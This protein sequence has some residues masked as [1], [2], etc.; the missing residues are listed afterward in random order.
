MTRHTLIRQT[1]RAWWFTPDGTTDRPVLGALVGE[2]GALIVDAGASP[3]HAAEFQAALAAAGLPEP[4]WVALSHWHWDHVFGAA[5]FRA[6]LIAQAG[7]ARMLETMRGWSWD[8]AALDERVA[9]GVEIS[10]CRDMIKAELP[11][12]RDLRLRTADLSF[13]DE[14]TIDL[15]GVSCQL[16]HVGGDHAEDSTIIH[17]PG[18]GVA[19]LSDALYQCIYSEP[20]H[21]TLERLRPA[22]RRALDLGAE[23]YLWGHNPEPMGRAELI[24]LADELIEA[25]EIAAEQGGNL[26]ASAAEMERRRGR[27]LNEDEQE[28][29]AAF[30]NGFGLAGGEAG[31]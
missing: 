28:D 18:E 21:Y 27:P 9:A 24:R 8:D 5:A 25:G 10:F 19:F 4:A 12:R 16:I 11:D 7:T 26:A 13:G 15:G 1:E 17:L 30:C 31:R 23:C 29:L 6:P 2:R 3:A 22:L 14:L 20:R